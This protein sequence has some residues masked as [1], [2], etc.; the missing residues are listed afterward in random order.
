LLDFEEKL[1]WN[2]LGFLDFISDSMMNLVIDSKKDE[3]VASVIK[4]KDL[5]P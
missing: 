2:L 4:R 1:D 5:D 3:R